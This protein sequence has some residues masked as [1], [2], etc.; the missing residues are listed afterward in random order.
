ML[1]LDVHV[2]KQSSVLLSG[3]SWFDHSYLVSFFNNYVISCNDLRLSRLGI[4]GT[5]P[6][7]E[8]AEPAK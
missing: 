6:S 1:F 8:I 2:H 7:V 5:K 4:C 3:V